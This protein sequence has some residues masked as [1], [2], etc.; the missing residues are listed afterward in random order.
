MTSIANRIYRGIFIVCLTSILVLVITVWVTNEA[1]ETTM[2]GTVP[3]DMPVLQLTEAQKVEPFIWDG[4]TN[5]IAFVPQGADAPDNLPDLFSQLGGQTEAEIEFGDQTFLLNI[6]H[7]ADGTLYW[8]RNISAFE[9]REDTLFGTLLLIVSA[10]GVFSL[11]L[12]IASSRKIVRPL[13]QLSRQIGTLPVGKAMPP[14]SVD[15]RDQELHDIAATFNHFLH[16]MNDYVEREQRLLNLASHELRTPIAV[17][18][19]ALDVIES[20]GQLATNDQITLR[21]IRTANNEM[22][23][24][25]QILLKLARTRVRPGDMIST[26]VHNCVTGILHDLEAAFD[27]ER[28]VRL[29]APGETPV[30]VMVQPTMLKMLLRNVVQNALQHTSGTITINIESSEIVIR[31]Q[32]EG[33]ITLPPTELYDASGVVRNARAGIEGTGGLGLYIVSLMCEQLGWSLAVDS[34]E[35]QGNSVRIAFGTAVMSSPGD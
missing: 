29:D 1:L 32:G 4:A 15:Y 20:R 21:R 13:Q 22:A 31:D 18:A 28:R 2:L 11:V 14:I 35:G 34:H 6:Q 26:D 19:G 27:V 25:I 23:E 3:D 30:V 33:R 17:T 5:K 16:E 7:T 12:A 24:N 9:T 10:I 8:A